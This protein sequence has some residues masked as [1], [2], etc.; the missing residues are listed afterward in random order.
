MS[1]SWF[2]FSVDIPADKLTTVIQVLDGEGRHMDIKQITPAA[3][4]RQ[5]IARKKPKPGEPTPTD[6][7][8]TSLPHG[9]PRTLAEIGAALEANGYAAKTASGTLD[10]LIK[11]GQVERLAPSTYQRRA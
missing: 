5:T 3:P 7:V 9:A 1:Q 6:I 8:L 11:L 4:P 2:R 10:R